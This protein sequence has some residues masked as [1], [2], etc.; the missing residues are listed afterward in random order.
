MSQHEIYQEF[1]LFTGIGAQIQAEDL[2]LQFVAD[3]SALDALA[4]QA[5]SGSAERVF[6]SY[7]SPLYIITDS[8]QEAAFP[9]DV[10]ATSPAARFKPRRDLQVT[11]TALDERH[12]TQQTFQALHDHPFFGAE[13]RRRMLYKTRLT[14]LGA[15]ASGSLATGTADLLLDK[16]AGAVSAAASLGIIVSMIGFA[17]NQLVSSRP[18]PPLRPLARGTIPPIRLRS[19]PKQ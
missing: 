2:G 14:A 15:L 3:R 5:K 13:A 6:L 11:I 12:I 10:Y 4:R 18:A 17:L 16:H 9:N 19:K 7:D 1:T 8:G